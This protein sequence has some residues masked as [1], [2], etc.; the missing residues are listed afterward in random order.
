M[1]RCRLSKE[2]REL[3]AWAAAYGWTWSFTGKTHLRW[4]HPDLPHAVFTP[5]TP[6]TGES[7]KPKQKMRAAF[8]AATGREME[9]TCAQS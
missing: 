1:A 6:H 2:N 8:K 9:E 7:H 3:A 5:H 4:S